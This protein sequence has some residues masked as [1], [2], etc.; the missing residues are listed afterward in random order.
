[1]ILKVQL[2]LKISF[3]FNSGQKYDQFPHRT[4]MSE[5]NLAWSLRRGCDVRLLV[6]LMYWTHSHVQWDGKV[7][8]LFTS[9]TKM[10]LS[11][12]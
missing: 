11:N 3:H 8:L 2:L 6:E 9:I 5:R 10:A 1:M 4:D 12:E 7:N